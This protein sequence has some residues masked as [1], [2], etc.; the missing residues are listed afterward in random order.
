MKVFKFG[1]ASVKNSNSIKN[2]TRI[3][4]LS[5][6]RNTIVVISAMGKTTNALERVVEDYLEGNLRYTKTLKKI[7]EEHLSIAHDLF[8]GT[9]ESPFNDL[10]KLIEDLEKFLNINKSLDHSFVYD[11]VV[12]FGELI[13]TKII[14]SYL[15]LEG[16]NNYWLDVRKCLKTDSYYRN[17]NLNWDK[18][19]ILIRKET[20]NKSTVITQGF[21]A[22]DL[23][24]Y[25][26]TLG[27]EGS[28]Y[29][30]AIFAFILNAESLTIWKDVPGVLNADPRH[31]KTTQLLENMSYREAIELAYYGASVIHPKTLQ[32]LQQKKIPL[33]VK[34]F[35]EPKSQGTKVFEDSKLIPF[36]PCFILK[37]NQILLQLSTLDFSFIVEENISEIFSL[38]DK[39]KMR[40]EMIQNSAISFAVCIN[41]KY[42]KLKELVSELNL[43][44][45]VEVKENVSLH[46]IRHFDDSSIKE[47]KESGKKILLEQRTFETAQFILA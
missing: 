12:G 46:T 14:S 21:I 25:A 44:F 36:V 22:S 13:S 32:P 45:K 3:L 23:K 34:S 26:T 41:D 35:E 43:K 4:K 10:V 40:V 1:G 37:K 31:F 8:E 11:Q 16:I 9:E 38:M 47:I 42:S 7:K 15:Q 27:R 17:A 33:F 2:M 29:T 28:D 20:K 6:Y 5:G 19:K 39:Y 24:G 18:T 30:A